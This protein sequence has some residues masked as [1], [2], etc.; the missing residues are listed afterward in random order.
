MGAVRTAAAS[1]METSGLTMGTG[2]IVAGE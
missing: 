2:R 1:V